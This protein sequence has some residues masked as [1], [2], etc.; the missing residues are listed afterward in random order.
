MLHAVNGRKSILFFQKEFS[1]VLGFLHVESVS[2]GRVLKNY[3]LKL[4]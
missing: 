3:L 4:L 1:V 2:G